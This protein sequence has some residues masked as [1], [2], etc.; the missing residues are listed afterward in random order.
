M[1]LV[2]QRNPECSNY[3]IHL[4]PREKVLDELNYLPGLHSYG[5]L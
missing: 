4:L 1:Y 2:K 5:S 3:L